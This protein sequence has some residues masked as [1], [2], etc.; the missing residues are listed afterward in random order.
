MSP[1]CCLF[2]LFLVF[3]VVLVF[4][5]VL[6]CVTLVRCPTFRSLSYWLLSFDDGFLQLVP[7]DQEDAYGGQHA[8]VGAEVC[9]EDPLLDF[10]HRRH[11]AQDL[12]FPRSH[13]TRK[14]AQTT[15]CA[16]SPFSAHKT[17]QEIWVN[18]TPFD[19]FVNC[20]TN[21]GNLAFARANSGGSF[22]CEFFHRPLITTI[23]GEQHQYCVEV[24]SNSHSAG[25]IGV[26]CAV[27]TCV[28]PVKIIAACRTR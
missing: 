3:F 5:V 25:N 20:T 27:L 2:V 9:T 4:V 12:L 13:S 11:F 22:S 15:I 7:H 14:F 28:I 8:K 19:Y 18:V 26:R 10:L 17:K 23:S 24:A 16:I 6:F 21:P 1:L